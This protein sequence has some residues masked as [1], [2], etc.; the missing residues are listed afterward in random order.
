MVMIIYLE[1]TINLLIS[2]GAKRIKTEEK[3]ITFIV[4]AIGI[5]LVLIGG[6]K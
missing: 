1:S 3:M 4:L 6:E 5:I 2:S